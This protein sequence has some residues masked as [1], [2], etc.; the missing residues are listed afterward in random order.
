MLPV[1]QIGPL[2]VQTSLLLA[3]IG[4]WLGLEFSSR[5]ARRQPDIPRGFVDSAVFRALLLGLVVARL[6]YAAGSIEAYLNDPLALISPLPATMNGPAGLAAA[7][8]TIAWLAHRRRVPLRPLLDALAPGIGVLLAV[9]ALGDLTNGTALG[10]PT[11]LP[12]AVTLWDVP[13]HPVQ[14]YLAVPT[15]SLALWSLQGGERP[16]AGFDFLV[17][18][19]GYALILLISGIWREPGV[20]IAGGF[21]QEQFIAWAALLLLTLVGARWAMQ[22]S[23]S[24]NVQLEKEHT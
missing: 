7:I 13:R 6:V 18:T 22:D 24:S 14:L 17:V 23:P 16:F 20:V 10:T 19:G 3:L 4:F 1:L 9:L 21:R 2:V 5:A 15:L 8:A 11:D 12:W